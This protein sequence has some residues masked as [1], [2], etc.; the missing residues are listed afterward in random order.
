[1]YIEGK[2]I[3]FLG[4]LY[5][6]AKSRRDAS[7]DFELWKAQYEG[8]EKSIAG[9]PLDISRNITYELI[10]SQVST[11]IPSA[12][13]T[14]ERWSEKNERNA[15]RTERFLN[16]LRNAQPF[17]QLNDLDERS[18]YIYGTSLWLVEWDDSIRTATEQGG[19]RITQRSIQDFVPQPGLYRLEEMDYVFV[20]YSTTRE[21]VV[22]QYGI[23]PRRAE[24]TSKEP[25]R[26]RDD[27][28]VDVVICWYRDERDNICQYAFSGEVELADITD[29]YSRK[30]RRC[31]RCGRK[32]GICI[33]RNPQIEAYNSEYE[34]LDRDVPLSD[35]KTIPALSTVYRDGKVVTKKRLVP[36][37]STPDV[38]PAVPLPGE[39]ASAGSTA[40]LALPEMV[41]VEE[42]E[43]RP[44]RLPWYK[45]RS[46]PV[47]LRRNVSKEGSVYGQSDCETIRPQQLEI[48]KILHRMHQKVMSGTRFPFK[49]EDSNFVMDNSIHT[50]VLNLKPNESP[51][52]YG[53]IDTT[54]NPQADLLLIEEQYETAKKILGITASYQGQ[55]DATARSGV[56][57]Q[58]QVTQSAGRLESKRS[59]KNAAYADIDRA[60]FELYLAF[61]DEPRPATYKDEMGRLH[62]ETFSRY[63]FIE[64]DMETGQYYYN[65]RFLFSAEPT[66]TVE[67][68]REMLWQIN[69][70]NLAAGTYGN[71]QEPETLLRYWQQQEKA[72]Y[73]DAKN[74]V[75]YFQALLLRQQAQADPASEMS[76]EAGEAAL[77]MP[78]G[79]AGENG[80]PGSLAQG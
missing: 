33:C 78:A 23:S 38:S 32:E 56:A 49:P 1:M 58:L 12:K 19:V 22:R 52:Q 30:I 41:E 50:H 40:G 17:E 68:Q 47:V 74:N 43:L 9:I 67:N 25:E 11:T 2:K 72:H 44:T 59:L 65:D 46:F 62:N 53:V 37:A 80:T 76:A 14:A 60:I 73:P 24:D 3:D 26:S 15:V 75:E 34:E 6:E 20:I 45:P 55:A 13:V 42:P 27:D 54:Y 8:T 63:D 31:R 79:A 61:A 18:A 39:E 71:P 4:K 77:A 57:K 28:T 7:E 66:N 21:D 29:Y 10:E 69:Q 35:G 64:R 36:A 48:N 16:N 51:N 5:E 70:S